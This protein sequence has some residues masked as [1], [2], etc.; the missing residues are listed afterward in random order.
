LNKK[1][2]LDVID[3]Q[4]MSLE[5][6]LKTEKKQL[7]SEI[8]L[9]RSICGQIEW[10]KRKLHSYEKLKK[11]RDK[12]VSEGTLTQEDIQNAMNALCWGH[13]SGCCHPSKRC[14]TQFVVATAIGLSYEDLI[15]IFE[16]KRK[17]ADEYLTKKLKT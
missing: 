5:G 13:I 6:K 7:K 10:I 8:G 9:V 1:K 15:E 14:P 2:F 4:I 17:A 12:R 11:I 16:V 3:K